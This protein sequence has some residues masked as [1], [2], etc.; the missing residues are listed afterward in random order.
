MSKKVSIGR[1]SIEGKF[2]IQDMKI[3][4]FSHMIKLLIPGKSGG[5]EWIQMTEQAAR[6]IGFINPEAILKIVGK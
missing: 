5:M 2:W 4:T 3:D 6:D 1:P